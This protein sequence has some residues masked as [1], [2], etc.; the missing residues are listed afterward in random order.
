MRDLVQT[1]VQCLLAHLCDLDS[2]RLPL[3]APILR[4]LDPPD[5]SLRKQQET[6][7]A[8]PQLPTAFAPPL[9]TAGRTQ[10]GSSAPH[11]LPPAGQSDQEQIDAPMTS[12]KAHP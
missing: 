5:R 4:R 3:K 8:F 1:Y 9:R 12:R 11:Y 2:R 7:P 10:T 6:S